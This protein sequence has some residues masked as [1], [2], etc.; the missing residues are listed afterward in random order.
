MSCLSVSN[1]RPNQPK[2]FSTTRASHS[3][4]AT[5]EGGREGGMEDSQSEKK[6]SSAEPSTTHSTI[7]TIQTNSERYNDRSV[8]LC[9]CVLLLPNKQQTLLLLEGWTPPPIVDFVCWI[10]FLWKLFST[11]DHNRKVSD[12]NVLYSQ[13][14]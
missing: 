1:Q 13:G 7:P 11:N 3:L 9:Q 2:P 10:F 14:K 6:A 4:I 8:C 12:P 5:D